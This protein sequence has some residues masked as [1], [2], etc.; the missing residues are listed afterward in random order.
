MLLDDSEIHTHI[1]IGMPRIDQTSTIISDF[2]DHIREQSS[3]CFTLLCYKC[4]QYFLQFL[5]VASP[6]TSATS[7]GRE[8]VGHPAPTATT[9]GGSHVHSTRS[10][11]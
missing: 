11:G 8:D 7:H 4:W 6:P 2:Y 5:H 9:R 10:R 1:F 3:I